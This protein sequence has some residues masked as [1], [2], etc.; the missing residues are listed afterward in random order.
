MPEVIIRKYR[1]EDREYVRKICCDTGFMG[2]P[3]EIYFDDRN[4]FADFW[5]NYYTDYEPESCFVAEV[6]GK[7]VGYIF[8]CKDTVRYYKIMAR[9]ILPRIFVNILKRK[10]KIGK[11]TL[12]YVL[13][14]ILNTLIYGIPKDF[15]E[16]YPAHLH[17][18][19]DKNYRRMGIG[20]KLMR[21]Y[22][23]YLKNEG[24]WGVHLGTTSNHK[25]AVP[26]YQ[27]IGFK[28]LQKYNQSK[29]WK[30]LVGEEVYGLTFGIDLRK[31]N[32][33]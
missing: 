5:C 1:P 29:I 12:K 11:K 25:Q 17:I 4:L 32:L 9:K 3:M 21:A 27:K 14:A 28:L 22:F 26:F 23:E 18:N 8:G 16:E 15:S 30:D 10:Y 20:S 13:S 31:T 7:V 2:E 6:D 24:I 19:I 33:D